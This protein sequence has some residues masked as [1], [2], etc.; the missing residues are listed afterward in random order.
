M[1]EEP[2]TVLGEA[3]PKTEEE[4]EQ[5][6]TKGVAAAKRMLRFIDASPTPYHAVAHISG[7]LSEDGFQ[8]LDEKEAWTLQPGDRRY[9][10]RDDST[11][12]AFV[13]GAQS[14]AQAG[15]RII[16]AHTDSPNLRLKP[17]PNL[18]RKG[19]LQL[20][21]EVYGGALLS[22]WLDRDLSIAGRLTCND[23]GQISSH[24]V[25]LRRPLARVSTLAVHLDRKV[26]SEGLKLN[27]QR[28]MVPIIGL[29]DELD[30]N[31]ELAEAAGLSA[32]S[33]VGHRGTF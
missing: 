5:L 19:Y 26:N 3:F 22:T 11:L 29:G 28:H 8:Q 30:L 18:S 27:K 33:I 7:Q 24:I 12:V 13:V 4:M 16:G 10:V 25:D 31:T 21:V 9:V 32:E 2:T 17:A 15:Y 23:D 20:G 14:P 6:R 1:T